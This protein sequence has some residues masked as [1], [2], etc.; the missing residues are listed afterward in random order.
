M[1]NKQD[2]KLIPSFSTWLYEHITKD[3]EFQKLT[4]YQ[5]NLCIRYCRRLRFNW[6][7]ERCLAHFMMAFNNRYVEKCKPFS[8]KHISWAYYC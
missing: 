6:P 3:E 1:N 5:K 7:V 4:F 2:F 8:D